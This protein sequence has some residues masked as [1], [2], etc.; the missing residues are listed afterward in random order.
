MIKNILQHVRAPN[1]R[2]GNPR[3]LYLVTPLDGSEVIA[4]P[5]GYH[6]LQAVPAPMRTADGSLFTEDV[7]VSAGEYKRLLRELGNA[8]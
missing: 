3:R 1:D 4:Y 6:G 7:Y 8:S 5:E 2:N